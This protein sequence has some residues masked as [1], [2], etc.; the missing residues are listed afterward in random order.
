MSIFNWNDEKNKLLKETRNISFERIVLA[1]SQNKILEVYNHPNENRYPNQKIYEI[2]INNYVYLVPFIEDGD[3]IFL[4]T[5]IPSRKATKK[6][7][8][9]RMKTKYDTEELEILEKYENQKLIKTSTKDFDIKQA[10]L[11]AQN[12]IEQKTEI[13]IK[14]SEKD[15]KELKLKE[16]ETGVPFDKII[17]ALIHS[18]LKNN[19]ELRI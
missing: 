12:T 18:Y 2:E 3:E 19:F 4:K 5:I 8:K 11:S 1:I 13:K 14:V 15:I 6:F 9:T 10:I 17:S 7:K 16:F